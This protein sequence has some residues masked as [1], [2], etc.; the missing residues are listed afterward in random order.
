MDFIEKIDEIDEMWDCR[1]RAL[2]GNDG[3]EKL[4][5]SRITIFGIGGVGSFA[6]EA[7]ARA[8]IG[9]LTLVDFDTVNLSNLNRQIIALTNT[10]GRL[11]TDVMKERIS[12]INPDCDV[13]IFS[14]FVNS[15]NIDDFLKDTPDYVI[16]AIDSVKS[17]VELIERCTKRNI[18]VVSCMGMG[19][20]IDNSKIILEDISKTHTCPLARA[21]RT[22]L[23]KRGIYNNVQTVFSSELPVKSDIGTPASISFVP[24]TAGLIMARVAIRNLL[25]L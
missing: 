7:L 25:K 21:V 3:V 17:K 6:A 11:K 13:R 8:G 18:P 14:E 4:K 1:T 19:N 24:S 9:C 23:K 20:K 16:D 5:K 2:V 22:G 10:I 12:L 15:E